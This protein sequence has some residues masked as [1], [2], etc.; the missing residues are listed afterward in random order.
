MCVPETMSG[1]DIPIFAINKE[2]FIRFA[3]FG[4]HTGGKSKSI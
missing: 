4:G 1:K 3:L 2:I